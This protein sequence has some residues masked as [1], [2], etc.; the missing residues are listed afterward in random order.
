MCGR[1]G[2]M[3][4][5]VLAIYVQAVS[6]GE[7]VIKW[8]T[9]VGNSLSQREEFYGSKEAMRIAETVLLSQRNIG[10]WPRNYDRVRKLDEKD[11]KK[12]LGEKNRDDTSFDNGSTHSDVRYLAKIYRAGGD[13]RCKEAFLRGV[14]FM[15]AAQYKNGGW[16]QLYPKAKG[17]SKYITFNDDAMIGVM[18]TLRDIA[19]N[20]VSYPFVDAKLRARCAA[21]VAK[22]I[23]CILKCQVEVEGKKT[24][25]C[26][27]HDEKSLVPRKARSFEP[28]SLSGGESVGIVRFLMKIDKPSPEIIAAVQG[29]VRW[30]DRA[31]LTG[32]RVIKKKDKSAPKGWDIVVVKDAAAPPMWARF[33]EIGT[34]KPIFCSRDGVARDTLA[35][36]SHERRNG[37]SWLGY[38]AAGL[39]GKDYPAWQKKWA[40]RDNVLGKNGQFVGG[41]NEEPLEKKTISKSDKIIWSDDFESYKDSADL[42]S[43]GGQRLNHWYGLSNGD[44]RGVTLT[45]DYAH[46]GKQS[47]LIFMKEAEEYGNADIYLKLPLG[48]VENCVNRIGYEGWMAF[49]NF[50]A[51]RLILMCEVWTG[52]EEHYGQEPD[53]LIA[54]VV[55]YNGPT[56]RWNKEVTDKHGE[57][58]DGQREY[59]QGMD[60]WH[61]FKLTCSF[62]ENLQYSF[63][64]DDDIWEWENLKLYVDN[65]PLDYSMIEVNVRLY[66]PRLEQKPGGEGITAQL[67]VDD[68]AL[69]NEDF[70]DTGK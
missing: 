5:C 16:P 63:Q 26:A 51:H 50:T 20:K 30:F 43:R 14:E 6:G 41:K 9:G 58:E 3:V 11:K 2:L 62:A 59:K 35:E 33:Y 44:N 27:Q 36:I 56:Q 17:Y 55:E 69:I 52:N 67:A 8:N 10:G 28:T 19:Q 4:V 34:N 48:L 7:V 23:E 60:V 42:F 54:S 46:S 25:W 24:A 64:F 29:A 15:L 65:H 68:V 13:E 12:L 45:K 32:I 1:A 47:A 66:Y 53:K 21:A 22:G 61:Y 70:S 49:D 18:T 39:V 38:Y 37:Y 31:K 57:F 40:P